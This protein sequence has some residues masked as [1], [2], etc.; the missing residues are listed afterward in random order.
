MSRRTALV[1]LIGLLFLCFTLNA[2]GASDWQAQING[3]GTFDFTVNSEANGEFFIDLLVSGS[4]FVSIQSQVFGGENGQQL[5]F[6][7]TN[8]LSADL[9]C[10]SQTLGVSINDLDLNRDIVLQNGLGLATTQVT[11]SGNFISFGFVGSGV[12]SEYI[13]TTLMATS[14]HVT[15]IL[16]GHFLVRERDSNPCSKKEPKGRLRLV[17]QAIVNNIFRMTVKNV[18]DG[19]VGFGQAEIQ[20]GFVVDPCW[21]LPDSM[22]IWAKLY[23]GDVTLQPGE[24]RTFEF[25]LPQMP[26]SAMKDFHA[27][28]SYMFPTYDRDPDPDFLCTVLQ[29]GEEVQCI[30]HRDWVAVVLR[31]RS[32]DRRSTSQTVAYIPCFLLEILGP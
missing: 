21:G 17:E 32:Q 28:M 23:Q 12:F 20:L 2:G 10:L 26:E 27:Y 18:G 25:Y 4:G 1:L 31:V 14:A 7:D 16:D 13:T 11:E 3:T 24:T 8:Q 9:L 6:E 29:N 5:L 15:L 19:V 30:Q 22:T